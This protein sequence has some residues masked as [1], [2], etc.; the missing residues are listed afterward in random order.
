[1]HKHRKVHGD[2]KP[3][4]VVRVSATKSPSSASGGSGGS[5][6][7]DRSTEGARLVLIDLDACVDIGA[8]VGVKGSTG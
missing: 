5:G 6:G 4:N 8:P 1:M 2:V 3:L 7:G